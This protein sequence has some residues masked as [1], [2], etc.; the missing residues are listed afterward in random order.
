MAN[1]IFKNLKTR[2][3][4]KQNTYEYWTEG[5][6]KDYIPFYGEVCFCEIPAPEADATEQTN[7]SQEATNAPTVLFKVGT[8]KKDEN[9]NWVAGT[10]KTFAQLNWVSALAAD[11]YAWAKAPT[12]PVYGAEEITGIGEYIAKYVD[13]ELGI[14]VDTNTVYQLA[15][16]SDTEYKLQSK[17]AG[18]DAWADVECDHIIIPNPDLSGYKEKQDAYT[19]EGSTVK[20]VTKV[21]Q[22]ANGEVTVT[23]GDIAFPDATVVTD[24]E[25]NGNIVVDGEEVKVFDDVFKAEE[26]SGKPINAV[27]GIT[28]STTVNG[29]TFQELFYAM[30][31]PYQN[32]ALS[33]VKA[34]PNGGTYMKGNKQTITSV[35]ATVTKKTSKIAKVEL[36]NGA[37][38][39]DTVTTT[40][41]GGTL[42]NGGAVSFS[43]SREVSSNGGQYKV[44]VYDVEGKTAEAS[45]GSFTFIN[46]YYYGVC[47]ASD[48]LNEALIE[49]L[50]Q[51]LTAKA[52]KAYDYRTN[53][54]RMVIAYPKSYGIIKLV[55]DG[56]G[57]DN[58]GAFGAGTNGT[59]TTI[60]VTNEYGVTEDYY[61]Y[62]NGVTSGSAKMTFSY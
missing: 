55:K 33:N 19:A 26:N 6:G 2:I 22:N 20:T 52:T 51:D 40:S 54:Q 45:T 23:Y 25:T 13:E 48:T 29:K 17:A 41:T 15:K 11:V 1:E 60:S 31:F 39:V 36:Y 37:T 9:G 53:S 57:L 30:M 28:T 12:K 10:N 44:K 49:S 3:A 62:A 4:L 32:P 61:V 5:E 34:S 18:T 46:P 59:P 56:N 50:T 58:T 35:T 24:S 27:G 43:V 21:E 38:L 47:G 8:G 42:E 16:V 7:G 14:S